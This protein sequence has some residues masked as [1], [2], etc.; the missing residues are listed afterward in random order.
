MW[1]YLALL[2]AFF[3]ALSN[4]AR[5]THGSL[6]QP[7]ELSWWTLLL[8]LPLTFGLLVITSSPYHHGNGY[9]LPTLAA[10]LI[11]CFSSVYQFKAYKLAE[12]SVVSPIANFLP[13]LLV[14]MS[15][16]FLGVV[17][18]WAGL[19]GILFV[20]GGVYYSSVS[21][22]HALFHPLQQ[23]LGNSGSRAMLITVGLWSV[24]SILE[25]IALRTASPAYVLFV[26]VLAMFSGMSLYLLA[27]PQ[28]Q[29]TKRGERII[30][31]WGWHIAAIAVFLTLS[32]FFQMQALATTNPSYVLSVKRLDV[33]IT[34]LFSGIFLH[35]RHLLKRFKGSAIA[36]IGVLIIYFFK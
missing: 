1:F 23:M 5:R 35:E 3:N 11:G 12:A 27:Q 4:I 25:K 14:G 22:K 32:V 7:A 19:I 30:K 10:G 8:S 15:F 17:P 26:L 21:G 34:I 16:I 28:K 31:R 36:L 2:S 9:L 29:R 24:S 18:N 13:I 20:V 6:A 33:L